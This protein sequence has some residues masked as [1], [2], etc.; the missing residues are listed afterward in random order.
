MGLVHER[1]CVSPLPIRMPLGSP[2]LT[3]MALQEQA[4]VRVPP[5]LRENI[6][7]FTIKYGG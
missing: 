6:Q 1:G 3:G 5:N 2:G 4:N 7:S